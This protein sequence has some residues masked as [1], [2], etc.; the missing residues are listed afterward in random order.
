MLASLVAALAINVALAPSA[1]AEDDICTLVPDAPAGYDFS[2]A[3]SYHDWCYSEDNL[4]YTREQCDMIFHNDMVGL[5]NYNY[6]ASGS[7]LEAADT[8]YWGV[9]TFGWAFYEG[10]E[11]EGGGAGGQDCDPVHD[12]YYCG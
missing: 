6:G 7:C 8:Y 10:W 5:C 12:S 4:S 1:S 2:P 11:G 9:R 3:C